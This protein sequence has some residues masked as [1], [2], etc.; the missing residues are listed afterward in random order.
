MTFLTSSYNLSSTPLCNKALL[1]LQCATELLFDSFKSQVNSLFLLVPHSVTSCGSG[2]PYHVSIG[3]TP[4]LLVVS[5]KMLFFFFFSFS[6]R[7]LHTGR[8]VDY[9]P[10]EFKAGMSVFSTCNVF[11]KQAEDLS[12][13]VSF[14][15]SRVFN[16]AGIFL[17]FIQPAFFGL[18]V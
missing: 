10:L 15:P 7:H 17:A 13:L 18:L 14:F 4:I 16:R 2:N 6:S 12:L 11:P 3:M 9:C 5:W 1:F 8:A